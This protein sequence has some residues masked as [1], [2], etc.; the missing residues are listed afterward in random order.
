MLAE[1]LL[2]RRESLNLSITELVKMSGVHIDEYALLENPVSHKMSIQTFEKLD[3][4]MNLGEE[5][6]EQYVTPYRKFGDAL[7]RKRMEKG[8]SL[9]ELAKISGIRKNYLWN[10]ENED[11]SR[12][13]ASLFKKLEAALEIEDSENFE[14][15]LT[16]SK[17]PKLKFVN[18]GLFGELLFK[19]RL[20]RL[21][22][23]K[24]VAMK[25]NV[26]PSLISKLE[27][28]SRNTLNTKN[29]IKIM[30]ALEF[31]EEEKGRYL[32]KS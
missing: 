22:S 21:L 29:A 11:K 12:M 24:E 26:D 31:S 7:K 17:T 23:Q 18:D 16:I 2:Y 32:V 5:F 6:K 3:K 4:I 1:A 30:N 20:N 10:L 28:G 15:F 25:A 14:P 27:I 9:V 19:K 13:S 8:L